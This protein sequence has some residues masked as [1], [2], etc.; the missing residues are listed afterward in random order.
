M[1]ISALK[2]VG[3]YVGTSVKNLPK[4]VRFLAGG[5][6]GYKKDVLLKN[7]NDLV[8]Y[9]KP[10]SSGLKK[11]CSRII[12]KAVKD[13]PSMQASIKKQT[14]AGAGAVVAGVALL[15]GI[16]KAAVNKSEK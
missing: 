2:S 15:G 6:E 7:A 1:N 5:L 10:D 3:N 11:A 4:N 16:V 8:N 14:L 13:F 12:D 9:Y